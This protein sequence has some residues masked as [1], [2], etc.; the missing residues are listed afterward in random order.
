MCLR[1]WQ[2]KP[3]VMTALNRF[4]SPP[5]WFSFLVNFVTM[6]VCI[7]FYLDDANLAYQTRDDFPRVEVYDVAM[8]A[9]NLDLIVL[10]RYDHL[11]KS[12]LY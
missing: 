11:N 2:I 4:G 12:Y 5:R 10:V 9:F 3:E 1:L 6:F 7:S 8:G